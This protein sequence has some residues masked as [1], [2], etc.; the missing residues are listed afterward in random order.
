MKKAILLIIVSVFYLSCAKTEIVGTV[1]GQFVI[2]PLC[3]IEPTT[4]DELHPCGLSFEALDKIYNTYKVQ[5]INTSTSMVVA[6][7]QMDHTGLYSFS[8]PEGSYSLD[9]TPHILYGSNKPSNDKAISL[10]VKASQTT[11]MNI[12]VNTGLR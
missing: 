5:L 3:G 12:N 8:V 1:E 10:Q 11:T 4:A 7:K 2:A 6:E 9:Y